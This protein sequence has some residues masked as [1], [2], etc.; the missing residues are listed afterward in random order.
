MTT[1][2]YI[3]GEWHGLP[4]YECSDCPFSSLEEGTV[5]AHMA[6][7]HPIEPVFEPDAPEPVT[8]VAPVASKPTPPPT[9]VEAPQPLP[10]PDA[11]APQLPADTT[12]SKE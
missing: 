7:R 4:N 1:A 3:T 2:T 5:L 9:P 10:Q 8:T 12:K 11:E 6:Q